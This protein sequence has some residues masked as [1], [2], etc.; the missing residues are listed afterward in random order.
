MMQQDYTSQRATAA[1]SLWRDGA[2]FPT[3]PGQLQEFNCF[4]ELLDEIFIR[5]KRKR[6][7]EGCLKKEKEWKQ[8]NQFATEKQL[9]NQLTSNH[10]LQ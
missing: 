1:T 4:S 9:T 10:S 3:R 6:V 5:F 2:L 8:N 7:N